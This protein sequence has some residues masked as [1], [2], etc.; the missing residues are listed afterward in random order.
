M[1]KYKD[2]IKL[3]SKILKEESVILKLLDIG[4]Y[5]SINIIKQMI[6]N[7]KWKSEGKFIN[8]YNFENEEIINNKELFSSSILINTSFII[9]EIFIYDYFTEIL[10]DKEIGNL[11]YG[12]DIY[13][14]HHKE[15]IKLGNIVD[16][17]NSRII[18]Q[19]E[20]HSSE[21]NVIKNKNLLIDINIYSIQNINKGVYIYL[22][23]IQIDKNNW[24]YDCI[25]D[26]KTYEINNKLCFNLLDDLNIANSCGLISI[27][28]IG[29]I[30]GRISLKKN[31][32]NR[33]IED[34]YDNKYLFD[35]LNKIKNIKKEEIRH[36][37][38][39]LKSAEKVEKENVDTD[40]DDTDNDDTDNVDIDNDDTDNKDYLKEFNNEINSNIFET[41]SNIIKALE[42]DEKDM[43]NIYLYLNSLENKLDNN[44][45]YHIKNFDKIFQ[46]IKLDESIETE[47]KHLLSNNQVF[48]KEYIDEEEK[49]I[50]KSKYYIDLLKNFE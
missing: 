1:E 38:N 28:F 47:C 27:M 6:S 50:E 32:N 48:D 7:C 3:Y 13:V 30:I 23:V 21:I 14:E 12:N 29:I 44:I 8:V 11:D 22:P 45:E 18:I 26:K 31:I 40:N 33:D 4:N 39:R 25:I 5:P 19:N 17:S 9:N 35:I 24:A 36:N 15:K 34:N 46:K 20:I 2:N 42:K 37:K 10:F 41:N 43:D 49:K 16:I